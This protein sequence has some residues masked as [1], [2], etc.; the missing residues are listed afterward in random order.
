MSL[1]MTLAI[2][3]G[4]LL[5]AA[6]VDAKPRHVVVPDFGGP[7]ELADAGHSAVVTTLMEQYDVVSTKRWQQARAK[8]PGHGPQQWSQAA[9]AAGVDAVIDGTIEEQGRHHVLSVAVLDAMTGREIDTIQVRI[10]D[11]GLSDQELHKL[12]SDLDGL[13]EWINPDLNTTEPVYPTLPRHPPIGTTSKADPDRDRDR[14]DKP[15][16][17]HARVETT[18]DS[19]DADAA[20]APAPKKT[21]KTKPATPPPADDDAKPARDDTTAAAKPD[22]KST[23]D[24]AA[25]PKPVLVALPSDDSQLAQTLGED[26]RLVPGKAPHVPQPT[27]KIEISAGFFVQSRGM[28]WDFDPNAAGGPP[29][30]PAS[31]LQGFAVEARVYP[32]PWKKMDGKLSGLGFSFRL[33][34][35]IGSNLDVMDDT[36][37]GSYS[38]DHLAYEAGIHYRFPL[39]LLAIDTEVFYG[40]FNHSLPSDFPESIEIPDTAYQYIGG[41]LHLDLYITDRATVGVG[42]KYMFVTSQG[43]MVSEDWYGA[44]STN[45]IALDANFTVP[46]PHKMFV[47]GGI[48]WRRYYTEFEGSGAVTMQYGVW[49]VTDTSITGSALVGVQF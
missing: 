21:K 49:D 39:D 37:Y 1:K 31:G 34:K 43:D 19:G 6:P 15:T 22:D 16:P 35:S 47:R 4:A 41:G 24:A 7:R 26:T 28:G 18:D 10:G 9:K 23:D 40:G 14:D 27:P 13:L 12:Q 8:A 5:A 46:L 20:P 29:S 38:I 30:Y 36:G 3:G 45:G 33:Q 32:F 17:R 42:A 11:H 44:G 2:C 25:K 48:E